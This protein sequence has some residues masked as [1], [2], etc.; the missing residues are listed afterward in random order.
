MFLIERGVAGDF[1]SNPS[2][3]S[4]L[5]LARVKPGANSKQ[6][7]SEIAVVGQRLM[8]Q[9]PR[10]REIGDLQARPLRPPG[11]MSG[12]TNPFPKLAALFLTLA[13]LVLALAC[14]NVANLFLV[15]AAARQREMAVRAALG[16]GS[17]RL[18]R[19]LFTESLVVAA[20]SC[21]L[22]VALGLSASRLLGSVPL[23]S[24][25]PDRA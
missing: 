8:K 12:A 9:Y 4:M 3:R 22:G 19:Q 2:T 5:A 18:V 11:I 16:A 13:G 1:L 17:G 10:D 23:Q 25:L 6:I 7:Q 15:R 20:L 24:E 14:V 21:G